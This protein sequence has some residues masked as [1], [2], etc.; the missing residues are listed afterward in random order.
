MEADGKFA[1]AGDCSNGNGASAGGAGSAGELVVA[2]FGSA[3]T[4]VD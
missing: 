3:P 1:E 4:A 2:E